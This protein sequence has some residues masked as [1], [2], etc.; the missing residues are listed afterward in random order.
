MYSTS[1][2][3]SFL[4]LLDFLRLYLSR[5]I[6]AS[7]SSLLLLVSYN[8]SCFFF[9]FFS[10]FFLIVFHNYSC[11]FFFSFSSSSS[12]V[13][14]IPSPFS[15]TNY[16][17]VTWRKSFFSFFICK[18]SHVSYHFFHLCSFKS[19]SFFDNDLHWQALFIL[20]IFQMFVF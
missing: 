7:S 20:F 14:L 2:S 6:C 1:S 16:S 11:S 13:Y 15:Q 10:F 17:F 19:A 4:V 5:I 3:F 8:Y 9:F 18:F 12:L